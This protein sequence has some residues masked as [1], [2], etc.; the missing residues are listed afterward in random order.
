MIHIR[1]ALVFS[2]LVSAQAGLLHAAELAS[3]LPGSL[4]VGNDGS[5]KYAIPVSTPPGT[6]GMVPEIAFIYNSHAP[7][8]IMGKGWA[9]SGL[10]MVS[11][12]PATYFFDGT[13]D[14]VDYDSLDRYM[15]DG[16]RLIEVGEDEY[17]TGVETFSKIEA[18]GTVGQGP[19]SF[20]VQTKSGLTMTYG[21]TSDSRL[22]LNGSVYSWYLSRVEDTSGNYM[23]YTYTAP[24]DL[25]VNAPQISLIKYTGHTSGSQPYCE[26]KFHYSTTDR[27]DNAPI[28]VLGNEIRLD[29]RLEKVSLHDNTVAAWEYLIE[30]YGIN[31]YESEISKVKSIQYKY[32]TDETPKTVFEWQDQGSQGFVQGS[33]ASGEDVLSAVAFG[34]D[35]NKALYYTY[36]RDGDGVMELLVAK[37]RHPYDGTW[38]G[39]FTDYVT[40]KFYNQEPLSRNDLEIAYTHFEQPGNGN[41]PIAWYNQLLITDR[42][43]D[44]HQEYF[45]IASSGFAMC[46]WDS[47]SIPDLVFWDTLT[48]ASGL[49]VY[50]NIDGFDYNWQPYGQD[51]AFS[52]LLPNEDDV[53]VFIFDYN[54]DGLSDLL[55]SYE[56]SGKRYVRIIP[57]HMTIDQGQYVGRFDTSDA[58]TQEIHNDD[59]EEYNL[60]PMD[61]NGDTLSDLVYLYYDETSD[62]A[63]LKTFLSVGNPSASGN[64]FVTSGSSFNYSFDG[65][66][67]NDETDVTLKAEHRLIGGDFDGDGAQE[68]A[69]IY[70]DG[71]AAHLRL[72]ISQGD[73]LEE[74]VSTTFLSTWTTSDQFIGMDIEGDGKTD[75]LRIYKD[76]SDIK[77]SPWFSTGLVGDMIVKVENG[78]GE[79]TEVKY[80]PMTNADVYEKGD[81]EAYPRV[82]FQGPMYVTDTLWTDSGL[83][84]GSGDPILHE[85][86]YSYA[87]AVFDVRGLGFLGF[88]EVSSYDTHTQL[89]RFDVLEQQYPMLGM[90]KFSR[91][92]YLDFVDDGQGG[93]TTNRYGLSETTNTLVWDYVD[94]GTVFPMVTQSVEEKWDIYEESGGTYELRDPDTKVSGQWV[95]ATSPYSAVT[96]QTWFDEQDIQSG[97]VSTSPTSVSEGDLSYGNIKK[98]VVDYGSDGS[99][100]TVHTYDNLTT[101][102]KWHIGRLRNTVATHKRSGHSDIVRESH[103]EYYS[104]SGLIWK[105]TVDADRNALTDSLNLDLTTQYERDSYGNVTE[106][107]IY[108]TLDY[109]SADQAVKGWRTV[110]KTGYDNIGRY[111]AYTQDAA[112]YLHSYSST[113][114]VSSPFGLPDYATGPNGLKTVFEYDKLGRAT[115][116]DNPDSNDVTTSYTFLNAT[117]IT[118]NTF[119]Y[120]GYTMIPVYRKS[121]YAPEQ[122]ESHT[123]FDALGRAIL[124]ESEEAD[125]TAI[126]IAK[127]YNE[128]GQNIAA[129]EWSTYHPKTQNSSINWTVTEFDFLGRLERVT[130]PY[131]SKIFYQYYQNWSYVTEDE[132]G[133]DLTTSTLSNQRGEVEEVHDP[134]GNYLK[135]TYDPIGNKVKVERFAYGVGTPDSTTTFSYDEV[136]NKD[137]MV[138]PDM[139]TWSYVHNALGQLCKQTDA[140]SQ[141]SR[142][143]YDDVGRIESKTTADLVSSWEYYNQVGQFAFLGAL[144]ATKARD[145]GD[146]SG[147]YDSAQVNYYDHL[148]RLEVDLRYN[149]G[150]WAYSQNQYDDYSRVRQVTH[151]WRPAEVTDPESYLWHSFA[152]AY[153][154]NSRSFVTEVK[155]SLGYSWWSTTEGNY[156][157]QGRL[158]QY[159]NGNAIVTTN[160][161][162]PQKQL[163]SSTSS[164]RYG[165]TVNAWEFDYDNLGNVTRRKDTQR[166]L[167]EQ[168]QYDTLNRVWKRSFNGG[169]Y[170]EIA[171]YHANGN[172]ESRDV[173]GDG[174][175]DTYSYSGTGGPHAVNSVAGLSYGYDNNGNMTSRTG[176]SITW[177]SFNKPYWI[178]NDDSWSL[179]RY[180]ADDGRVI[181]I[182]HNEST[183]VSE[184]QLYF[185]PMEQVYNATPADPNQY[186]QWESWNWQLAHTRI[187]IS[188]PGGVIGT[189]THDPD[190]T[191][192][193][194]LGERRL[195][196]SDH[197]GNLVCIAN[198]D[199]TNIEYHSF[200]LWGQRRD[201]STWSVISDVSTHA[202]S[203]TDRGFTGHEML[204]N[205]GLVHMNGRIYDPLIG[206]FLSADSYVQFPD[207]PQSYNRYSYVLNNPMTFRDP[208]GHFIQFALPFI[209]AT[210]ELTLVQTIII[211]FQFGMM[212][213]LMQGASL[214]NALKAGIISA[215]AA[216]VAHYIGEYIDTN[217]YS[218]DEL[219]QGSIKWNVELSR[220][221]LHGVSQGGFAELAG[222]DFGGGFLAAF[223]G[224]IAGSFMQSASGQE[225]FGNAKAPMSEKSTS[226]IVARTTVAAVVGGTASE[227]GGGKFSNGA[228]TGAFVHLLNAEGYKN[229]VSAQRGHRNAKLIQRER[230]LNELEADPNTV[231]LDVYTT[232]EAFGVEDAHH[233]YVVDPSGQNEPFGRHGS[234]QSS[235]TNGTETGGRGAP[236]FNEIPVNGHTKVGEIL[237][238]PTVTPTD[239]FNYVEQNGMSGVYF[240]WINDCHS[241]LIDGAWEVGGSWAPNSDYS[242]R[243]GE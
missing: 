197:L 229:G 19:Q 58:R 107:K 159:T 199:G 194:N 35:I 113:Q 212:S 173:N 216:G 134:D 23:T 147:S 45:P 83:R 214:G 154:Y 203:G 218:G 13:V 50:I 204:D 146:P 85:T 5:T 84:D 169:A 126:Y 108:G 239:Y 242:G 136:G 149:D 33:M 192:T 38:S 145:P 20:V 176:S 41:D 37:D 94:G 210:A 47:D 119:A 148:G 101:S 32:G 42:N 153:V 160:Q 165:V 241:T 22:V 193:G 167:T 131:S 191:S 28:Y 88:E 172:I 144:K 155:D 115:F 128:L 34:H 157:E 116:V 53:R 57:A 158:K 123:Y 181:Q 3:T 91:T 62:K 238:P 87:H 138:D 54:G 69:V 163:L 179:F 104:G 198:G 190:A 171:T 26:V 98:L 102:G 205:L 186:Q 219:A 27:P 231:R 10:S 143:A 112:G 95:I 65:R 118:A 237:L 66:W 74:R 51:Q 61:I 67:E 39:V 137:A 170:A 217:Y 233:L 48:G 178:A 6:A 63:Y 71:T 25:G 55:F 92:E 184:K 30:Y 142:L 18:T 72:F 1:F 139:G 49:G 180:N 195:F 68:L 234:S 8:S 80:S 73:Y 90:V 196:Y 151:F 99:T 225:I 228:I 189:Y 93:T 208:S 121:V 24:G 211:A 122:P 215:A 4:L 132:G 220:A 40:Y 177:T 64:Q 12:A 223:T 185:G 150:K 135:Y 79:V 120:G 16:Q 70:K 213:A 227:V 156:D 168:F 11:R 31:D 124:Q 46:D 202:T 182:S 174:N 110:S 232:N 21:G 78:L 15:L 161:F 29:R 81:V 152:V 7:N 236:S 76:G 133:K 114:S 75:I 89:R 125:G 86:W 106:K 109:T 82:T 164:V 103:F 127:V 59:P 183:G 187:Y 201:P 226:Q 221:T 43:W 44:T 200:D 207:N 77:V 162:H 97:P 9:L 240:P 100:T 129:S 188:G 141:V 243:L 36:D 96:T 175:L 14:K 2:L 111:V 222:G 60:L 209:L 105:E 17:R 206:R 224:S 117:E 230:R 56:D 166:N 52:V 140:K 130:T 235:G